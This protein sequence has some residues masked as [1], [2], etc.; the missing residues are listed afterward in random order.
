M[1]CIASEEAPAG[2]PDGKQV[3]LPDG[4]QVGLPTSKQVDSAVELTID[5]QVDLGAPTWAD[6]IPFVPPV[7]AGFVIKVYDGDTIT[8]AARLPYADSPL[9]RFPVR[10]RGIDSP[11]IR[12]KTPAERAAAVAARDAL[13]ARI[14]GRTV[15][16]RN[17]GSEKF[18]RLLADV[19]VSDAQ[20]LNDWM[21]ANGFA[22]KYDGG[23][24]DEFVES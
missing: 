7:T 5:S 13:A 24:K 6:T 10:L 23:K 19:Y 17:T 2:L 16:L 14:F 22:V 21:I 8:V 18:G 3:G 1:G 11:E 9:Y 12:G 20:S 4:K 15:E